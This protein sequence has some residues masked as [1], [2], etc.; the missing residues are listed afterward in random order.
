MRV[1]QGMAI[2]EPM[3]FDVPADGP[4][5]VLTEACRRRGLRYTRGHVRE[6]LARH[7]Q[8]TSL[9]ALVETAP[10]LGLKAVAGQAELETLVE[11]EPEEL[12][13]LLHF[14]GAPGGF[15]L[16]EAV[17]PGGRGFRVWDSQQGSRE[18]EREAFA[19]R[20]SGI[21]VFLERAGAGGAEH[22]YWRRRAREV[23]W[24][25]RP[26]TELA[27]RWAGWGLGLLGL[28]VLSLAV[29]ARPPG[30]RLGAAG[31]MGLTALG[32]GASLRALT[33]KRGRASALCGAGGPV[34][35]ESVLRSAQAYVAGVPLAGLGTAF[36]GACLVLQGT[37]ALGTGP[38]PLWLAGAAF[39][40]ALPVCLLLLGV[41]VWMRRLCTL[42]L[43]VH[44]VNAVGAALFL[45]WLWPAVP[46]TA[47]ELGPAALLLVLLFGLLLFTVV[48]YLSRAAEDAE[49]RREHAQLL[50]SPLGTL[51][52]LAQQPRL[53]LEPEAVGARVGEAEAPHSLVVLAHPS[54][55]LCGPALEELEALV[56][57]QGAWLRAFIG[58][59]PL[60]P[61]DPRDEAICEA[62]AT[63]GV[64]FGGT[65]LLRA[66]HVARSHF[67][68]L[69][70]DVAP[71][72]LLARELGLEASRLDAAREQAAA[73]VR[74]A[75]VLKSRHAQGVPA[76]FL[77]G[78]SCEAPLSHIEA[79]CAQPALLEALTPRPGAMPHEEAPASHAQEA[80]EP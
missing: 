23:L 9:L 19:A 46:V 71:R 64:A 39:A 77:D 73:R 26:R 51:A 16:L 43:T 35:C 11:T 78:R 36:F 79:W 72:A 55:K 4:S 24:E 65:E 33:W 12:P 10:S 3:R 54:C 1:R 6:V 67:S 75:A 52:R 45:L 30:G 7:A 59:A 66:Y 31:V 38:A 32:L 21:V 41:Q 8:P 5:Q 58:V 15:G 80:H 48:P 2:L 28:G 70:A 27:G 74:A 62:L 34:D 68:R 14:G 60:D 44:A 49:V 25:Q 47:G 29:L 20:W 50:R 22:G 42:C 57:R 18:V 63:V 53:A 37:L 69:Y 56:E 61:E 76:F 17:L 13:A 40:C